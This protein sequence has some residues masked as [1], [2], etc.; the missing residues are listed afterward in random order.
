[1][2]SWRGI[3]KILCIR[4]DN[5]G[6]VMMSGP[7]FRALKDSFGCH[8]TLLTSSMGA[9]IVR[10]MKE[11]DEV[12]VSDLPWVKAEQAA[13]AADCMELIDRLK[14]VGFDAA[15]IFTVYS[16]N[17]LP[18]AMLAFLADIP[19]RLA[20]CRENPYGLLTDWIPDKEPYRGIRHQVERDLDLV[21]SIGAKV[22][23]NR[24]SLELPVKSGFSGG[25]E[26]VVTDGYLMIHPSVSEEKR[27]YPARRWADLLS[28]LR[29]R[30]SLPFFIT[31]GR[32]ESAF[33]EE[34][35]TAAGIANCHNLVGKT[36]IDDFVQLING[37][38]LLVSV[39]TSAV[40]I[41]AALQTPVVVLYALTNPQHTPW[42][43]PNRV[44]YFP[45][46]EALQSQNEVIRHVSDREHATEVGFAPA[47]EIAE[48][49][50]YLLA[51][52][53]TST[54]RGMEA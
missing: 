51:R 17:P 12:I 13:S 21:I 32:S 23:D 15:V 44:F 19:L 42:Q 49:C 41:A 43:V 53:K 48:A 2:K 35:I 28:E 30:T 9:P 52:Q 20:Y 34:I 10:F 25:A 14:T 46:P 5:M 45:V 36:T 22:Q 1:M 54:F 24:L 26:H 40:H 50:T 16:Q 37:A 38:S 39:N 47:A 3:K 7:A 11:I 8:L 18:S 29:K 27:K 31:G 4:P 33:A 6:D